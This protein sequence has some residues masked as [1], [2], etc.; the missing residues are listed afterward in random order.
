MQHPAYNDLHYL[1][2]VSY[3]GLKDDRQAL[4]EFRAVNPDSRFYSEATLQIAA[5][6]ADQER[7]DQAV[8]HLQKALRKDPENT[9]FLI[10][11]GYY[12][13]ETEQY[14]E[15]ERY[16]RQVVQKAPESEQAHFRLGVVYD[17]M[18]RKDESIAAMKRVIEINGEHANALNYLGYTYADLGINL[19]EAEALVRRALKLR[20]DDGYITDSLGW[21]FYQKG[22]YEEALQ[23]LL[24][25]SE[26]APEDPVIIEH[27]GDA[28]LK[29]GDKA[30]ALQYYQRSLSLREE[31][32]ERDKIQPKIDALKREGL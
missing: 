26:L 24:K 18:N 5:R 2:G 8:A 28:Y 14:E 7:Y 21:V 11:I 4:A 31:D 27:V 3:N 23:G 15:A 22:K 29:L 32:S 25:A 13:E 20:P 16:L 12:F 19:D 1:K 10:Y 17:K 30:K 6:Y 9:E